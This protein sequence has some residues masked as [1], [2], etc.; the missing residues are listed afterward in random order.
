M[1]FIS[2]KFLLLFKLGLSLLDVITDF[3]LLIDVYMGTA[4]LPCSF[5]LVKGTIVD[6]NEFKKTCVFYGEECYFDYFRSSDFD[7]I[8][9][10][11]LNVEKYY[12]NV[13]DMSCIS[14]PY[15]TKCDCDWPNL[16]A[17]TRSVGLMMHFA[18][19][20]LIILTLKE[21]IKLL[22]VGSFFF[23]KKF[24]RSST[25]KF[26]LNSPF[27]L[28]FLWVPNIY[29][30]SLE[31][32]EKLRNGDEEPWNIFVDLLFEDALGVV[33][34][35]WYI[36]F[37]KVTLIGAF[38]F[39]ITLI[40][41]FINIYIVVTRIKWRT[42]FHILR[43]NAGF[44][45][46]IVPEEFHEKYSDEKIITEK[47]IPFVVETIPSVCQKKESTILQLNE[48]DCKENKPKSKENESRT[49]LSLMECVNI[50]RE[51]LA[52]E[53]TAVGDVIRVSLEKFSVPELTELCN[54]QKTPYHKV[55][56]IIK[57]GLG[58]PLYDDLV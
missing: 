42:H 5:G 26:A 27:T 37:G 55:C 48:N 30:I 3:W 34:P 13:Y 41:V 35:S 20:S 45:Q 15:F 21:G 10:H 39:T 38:S 50:I 8:D 1:K 29:E 57:E 12:K 17:G 33:I 40:S 46:K 51:Q 6:T 25:F 58:M 32:I 44:D 18:F 16:R 2:S 47:K 9:L 28:F 36:Y 56:I 54:K 24:Q 22:I 7:D 4:D 49:K 14:P 19:Y 31:S 43:Q 53:D 23:T 11:T 52:I